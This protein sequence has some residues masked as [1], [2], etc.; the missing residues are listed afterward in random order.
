M[1]TCMECLPQMWC[2]LAQMIMP[3]N[4]AIPK[5]ILAQSRDAALLLEI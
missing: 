4:K 1:T 5:L 2:R 3:L